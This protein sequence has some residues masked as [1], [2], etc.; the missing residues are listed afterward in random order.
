MKRKLG[1]LST[2]CHPCR[3]FIRGFGP[4][5]C[6]QQRS[7]VD[8]REQGVDSNR[9]H[10][11]DS[12]HREF[13]QKSCRLIADFADVSPQQRLQHIPV[14]KNGVERVRIGLN[15][16]NPPITRVVLD[17]DSLCANG[18]ESSGNKV[19]LNILPACETSSV[20]DARVLATGAAG[21]VKAH[22]SEVSE[23]AVPLPE[24]TGSAGTQT[25]VTPPHSA[26]TPDQGYRGGLGIP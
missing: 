2:F 19:L 13:C 9:P 1:T 21:A 5:C 16:A 6:I 4:I 10:R 22:I 18:V 24:I 14:G 11:L 8:Q 3:R 17:L 7:S 25:R 12:S 23:A 15:R 26:R 20:P